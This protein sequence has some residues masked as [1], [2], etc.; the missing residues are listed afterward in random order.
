MSKPLTILY[1]VNAGSPS[2]LR[3]RAVP[4]VIP[5]VATQGAIWTILIATTDRHPG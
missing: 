3:T 1:F 5:W 4:A 2:E